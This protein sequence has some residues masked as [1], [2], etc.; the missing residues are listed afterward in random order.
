MAADSPH[1]SLMR[2]LVLL[3]L[4]LLTACVSQ[5]LDWGDMID[6]NRLSANG[7]GEP[8]NFADV[9]GPP[10]EFHAENYPQQCNPTSWFPD[11]KL[12]ADFMTNYGRPEFKRFDDCI[13]ADA[14]AHAKGKEILFYMPESDLKTECAAADQ[15][16][17]HKVQPRFYGYPAPPNSTAMSNA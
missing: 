4:V 17:D 12:P 13:N 7:T 1:A 16:P 15:Y 14:K 10:L 3:C 8:S 9:G 11:G 5:A 2:C 6:G